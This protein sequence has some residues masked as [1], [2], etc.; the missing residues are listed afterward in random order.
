[1]APNVGTV[2]ERPSACEIQSRTAVAAFGQKICAFGDSAVVNPVSWTLPSTHSP[3]APSG[4]KSPPRL[5]ISAGVAGMGCDGF[6]TD[7]LRK[8]D[9][10]ALH[11]AKPSV[12]E[13]PSVNSLGRSG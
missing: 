1:M 5:Q 4:L 8:Y 3:C 2:A 11:S 12:C 13:R 6:V 7:E 10:C 9:V